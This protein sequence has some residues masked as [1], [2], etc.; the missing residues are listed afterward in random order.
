MFGILRASSFLSKYRRIGLL[1]NQASFIQP[2][3]VFSLSYLRDLGFDVV[4]VFAPQ[5]G[6]F[7]IAQANMI[8]TYDY[9]DQILNVQVNSLYDGN[10]KFDKSKLEGIDCVFVDIQDIGARYYTYVWTSKLICDSGIDVVI[11]DRPNP[12]GSKKEGIKLDKDY[13]SFVGMME[14]YN[15]HG[16]TIGQIL[17]DYPN[18]KVV[19]GSFSKDLDWQE[20]NLE[21]IPTSPNIPTVNTAYF[22]VGFALL[23]ATNISEGR[24]TTYPFEVFGAPFIDEVK[25]KQRIEYYKNRYRIKGVE[26]IYHRFK[27]TFDKYQN[28]ICHGLKM[29]ITNKKEFHS[30]K[31]CLIV[32]KSIIDLYE[33]DFKFLDPPYEYEYQKMP[34]DILWGNSTLRTDIYQNFEELME[35]VL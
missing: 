34:I 22:Y 32:L 33:R 2:G 8:P 12:L 11:F 25:L 21:W 24:G 16:L 35:K 7:P 23:E 3:F 28:Q 6:L 19:D 26:F 14:I 13:F 17:Q 9:Y 31:T 27:P 29:I 20:L 1:I 5:H 10:Y 15:R 18:V 4:K 30:I